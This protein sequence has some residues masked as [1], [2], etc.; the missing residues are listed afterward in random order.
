MAAAHRCILWRQRIFVVYLHF[1]II[2]NHPLHRVFLYMLFVLLILQMKSFFLYVENISIFKLTHLRQY[3]HL[4]FQKHTTYKVSAGY[5]YYPLSTL[6]DSLLMNIV[7]S[8]RWETLSVQPESYRRNRRN[9][10]CFWSLML[11][12][13]LHTAPL[14]L[15]GEN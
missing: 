4:R 3:T 10:S 5:L 15:F 8:P 1:G 2:E 14:V 9:S 6:I 7:A 11:D 12:T 13:S